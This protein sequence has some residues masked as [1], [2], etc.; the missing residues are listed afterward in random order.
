MSKKRIRQIRWLE[1]KIEESIPTQPPFVESHAEVELSSGQINMTF[2]K[3]DERFEMACT[4]CGQLQPG[5]KEAFYKECLP[6]P[7]PWHTTGETVRVRTDYCKYRLHENKYGKRLRT[8]IVN[9]QDEAEAT[10]GGTYK[11]SQQNEDALLTVNE[12]E[13]PSNCVCTVCMCG[14]EERSFEDPYER[15]TLVDLE[16]EIL[17]FVRTNG[18]YGM[19]LATAER[20][21]TQLERNSI[22]KPELKIHYFLR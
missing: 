3:F 1:G 17:K 7:L 18:L 2:D 12:G 16:A 10:D 20:K 6:L 9:D 11:V 19:D 13:H 21:R 14:S 8:L 15:E 22:S 5:W 4:K